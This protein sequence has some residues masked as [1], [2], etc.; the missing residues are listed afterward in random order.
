MKAYPRYDEKLWRLQ[1]EIAAAL[2]PQVRALLDI[3]VQSDSSLT[4][5]RLARRLPV[6]VQT[7]QGA[8]SALEI[9]WNLATSAVTVIEMISEYWRDLGAMIATDTA[10]RLLS[11]GDGIDLVSLMTSQGVRLLRNGNSWSGDCPMRCRKERMSLVVFRTSA[12][13]WRWICWENCARIRPRVRNVIDYV[14]LRDNASFFEAIKQLCINQD[15]PPL[16]DNW[17]TA[18][19]SI[20]RDAEKAL[21]RHDDA[22]PAL[23]YLH[24]RGLKNETICAAHLGYTSG[25]TVYRAGGEQIAIPRGI[26]I[27]HYVDNDIWRVTILLPRKTAPKYQPIPHSANAPFWIDAPTPNRPV[28]LV[29]NALDAL[30]V[31]QAARDLATPVAMGATGFCDMRWLT[32]IATAQQLLLAFDSDQAGDTLAEL[33]QN[34]APCAVRLQPY[35]ADL[36]DIPAGQDGIRLRINTALGVPWSSALTGIQ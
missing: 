36:A 6:S 28:V 33:W 4:R 7:A 34:L 21:W 15:A 23:A 11:I 27:P 35:G 24:K 14:R 2:P 10:N 32:R 8:G 3:S 26:V 31:W 18:M 20:I 5:L 25:N 13:A 29:E 17:R 9:P 19:K 22:K 1:S 16:N 12:G 30:A